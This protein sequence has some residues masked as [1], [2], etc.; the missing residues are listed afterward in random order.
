PLP[1]TSVPPSHGAALPERPDGTALA[2]PRGRMSLGDSTRV[3]V[4]SSRMPFAVDEI[5]KLGEAGHEVFAADTFPYAPGS[6]SKYVED[7]IVTPSPSEEPEA[8]VDAVERIVASY[9]IELVIPC[10][11]EVFYL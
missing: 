7:G 1:A 5:R 3:L 4:T 8:Y 11:E 9:G 2:A 10:F 6:H